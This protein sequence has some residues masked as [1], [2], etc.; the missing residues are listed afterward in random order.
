MFTTTSKKPPSL[1]PLTCALHIIYLISYFYVYCLVYAGVITAFQT[2][3][4]PPGASPSDLPRARQDTGRSTPQINFYAEL[5]FTVLVA[6]DRGAM[7]LACILIEKRYILFPECIL[8]MAKCIGFMLLRSME[9]RKHESNIDKTA[10]HS[11]KSIC[12][13]G[14]KL[15]L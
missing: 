14:E 1:C 4:H 13:P 11:L 5:S 9:S 3:T 2:L 12:T 8:I 10:S 7:N 15:G 6:W